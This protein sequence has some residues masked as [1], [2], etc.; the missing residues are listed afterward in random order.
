[1]FKLSVKQR[2]RYTAEFVHHTV[3]ECS[4]QCLEGAELVGCWVRSGAGHCGTDKARRG[5]NSCYARERG[6][7]AC[8]KV[9]RSNIRT[10]STEQTRSEQEVA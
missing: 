9:D 10:Y 1:M 3:M 5:S 8:Y 7:M 6:S 2:D 4:S